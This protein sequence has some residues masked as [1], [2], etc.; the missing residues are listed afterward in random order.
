MSF[1][2]EVGSPKECGQAWVAAWYWLLRAADTPEDACQQVSRRI[3]KRYHKYYD[4]LSQKG[5]IVIIDS[6]VDKP[7]AGRFLI[8]PDLRGTFVHA[9]V[10]VELT[11][12]LEKDNAV[13]VFHI[14]QSLAERRLKE[15]GSHHFPYDDNEY[16]AI[17]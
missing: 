11:H 14:I 10:L 13:T 17:V 4:K 16:V 9:K 8:P 12:M 7:L 2:S 15:I 5:Q 1:A 3:Y 6:T